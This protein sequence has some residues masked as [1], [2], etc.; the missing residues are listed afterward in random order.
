MLWFVT[1]SLHSIEVLFCP[2]PSPVPSTAMPGCFDSSMCR[3]W[4]IEEEEDEDD[5]HLIDD[6]EYLEAVQLLELE[7]AG[8]SRHIRHSDA[9]PK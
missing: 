8:S 3:T 2:P 6:D 1:C 7:N 4:V 9:P 5:F